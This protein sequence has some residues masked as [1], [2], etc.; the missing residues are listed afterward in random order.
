M[1]H[2]VFISY[3]SKNSTVA[4]AI[5]HELEDKGIKCWMAPRDIPGG[6]EFGDLIDDAILS[7]SIFLLVYSADS[8]VSQWCKGE[9]NVAFSE[10]KTIIPYR[11]DATPLKGA[12]RVILNQTHWID[13]Y[14]DYK[15]RFNELVTIVAQAL[16]K[17][18]P[19]ERAEDDVAPMPTPTPTPTPIPTPKSNNIKKYWWVSLCVLVLGV[20]VWFFKPATKVDGVESVVNSQIAIPQEPKDSIPASDEVLEKL[21]AEKARIE[22]ENEALKQNNAELQNSNSDLQKNINDYKA[23]EA[24]NK[25]KE[26]KTSQ[27]TQNKIKESQ[28]YK[29]SSQKQSEAKSVSTQ[30]STVNSFKKVE[31]KREQ[32][33]T[34]EK[35]T[36]E[37][38]SQI[39][40]S[41]EAQVKLMEMD[42]QI[43][44]LEA[45]VLETV[46][47]NISNAEDEKYLLDLPANEFQ[48]FRRG[49]K[50]GIKIKSTGRIVV[51]PKYS[52]I[53]DLEMFLWEGLTMVELKNKIGFI[54][55]TG[56]EI[57][58]VIFD[59]AYPFMGRMGPNMTYVRLD[60][61]WGWVD[62]TG[63]MVTDIKYDGV[64]FFY[65]G[66]SHVR[67]GDRHGFIDATGKEVIPLKYD[68]A[69][70]FS[71]GLA[72]VELNGER[73]KI[74]K[75]GN[76]IE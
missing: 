28:E 42:A 31:Q 12:M 67:L 9:L 6:K 39:M 70:S 54:D 38:N 66:F 37:I 50:W 4:H 72:E 26:V 10:G 47:E 58:P 22:K 36:K 45:K 46:D 2:D 23:K 21:R 7:C 73:F 27:Q 57:V 3:S 69:R 30:S 24:Q 13:A 33:A 51:F 63:K 41:Q 29:S 62:K 65:D 56:K 76:R 68:Y 71:E 15:I 59:E 61:K 25:A 48:A 8:L 52:R 34:T 53:F 16:G 75:N 5:C 55:K 49:W 74:D 35:S 17:T 19:A 64:G 44:P 40:Q 32:V 14:P 18:L 1:N 43:E 11:I 60:D 20:A